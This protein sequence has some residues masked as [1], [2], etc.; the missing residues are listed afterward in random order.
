MMNQELLKRFK[1][2]EV[3]FHCPTQV[4]WDKLMVEL[5]SHGY[6]TRVAEGKYELLRDGY[7]IDYESGELEWCDLD[8][9]RSN[10]PHLLVVTLSL[11]DFKNSAE[12][13]TAT[14]DVTNSAYMEALESITKTIATCKLIEKAY[15]IHLGIDELLERRE[16]LLSEWES[17]FEVKL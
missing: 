12:P 2:G 6:D 13:L 1:D 11:D 15:D 4:I 5:N 3:V 14:P 16:E 9:Y 10:Y 7:C 8:Y 17:T